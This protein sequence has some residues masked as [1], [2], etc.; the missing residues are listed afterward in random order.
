MNP[1]FDFSLTEY[2]YGDRIKLYQMRQFWRERMK[3][4]EL[5][6]LS[7]S[8]LFQG[9]PKDRIPSFL[10][11]AGARR[12]SFAA[13]EEILVRENGSHRIGLVLS[14]V[15]LVYS[16]G[17]KKVLLN[18]LQEGSLFGV[19]GLF[20]RC[21]APTEIIAKHGGT[22]LFLNEENL[23]PLWEDAVLRRNFISFLTDRIRFL[24]RKIASF[25][26]HGAEGKLARFLLLHADESGCVPIPGSYSA[27]AKTLN[28]GRA[29]LYR[30]MAG[31]EEDGAIQ[32]EG[33]CIRLISKTSMQEYL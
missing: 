23:D 22:V 11:E 21:D 9:Y 10:K 25:T 8:I 33:K 26:A 1:F 15:L 24:N 12:Y 4:R 29:S 20:D 32:K 14:G 18:R 30:A 3:E 16:A 7:R 27:L 19:S 2:K 17:E 6:I 28:L 31:M 13:G 5:E